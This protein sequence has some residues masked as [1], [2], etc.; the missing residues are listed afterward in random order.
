MII[1]PFAN[2]NVTLPSSPLYPIVISMTHPQ[3]KVEAATPA[4]PML[5]QM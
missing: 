3:I 2:V 4:T 1:N 5:Y